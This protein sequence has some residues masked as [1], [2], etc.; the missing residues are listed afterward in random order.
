MKVKARKRGQV[1]VLG[2]V[3]MLLLALSLMMS[4]SVANAV[5]ERIRLQSHADAMAFSMAVVEART[6]NYI[7]YSNRA[8]AASFVSMTTTHVYAAI[9]GS[10]VELMSGMRMAALIATAIEFIVFLASLLEG[11]PDNHRQHW[12]DLLQITVKYHIATEKYK[13]IFQNSEGRFSNAVESFVRLAGDI[14]ASQLDMVGSTASMIQNTPKESNPLNGMGT[15][16]A[17]CATNQ[18]NKVGALNR[19]EFACAMEGS[20]L[21]TFTEAHRRPENENNCPAPSG[22]PHRRQ[23]MSNVV[24]ASRPPFLDSSHGLF[25]RLSPIKGAFDLVA[26]GALKEVEATLKDIQKQLEV[27]QIISSEFSN[28][29]KDIIKSLG[30]VVDESGDLIQAIKDAISNLSELLSLNIIP[31]DVFNNDSGKF[32]QELMVEIPDPMFVLGVGPYRV[33]GELTNKQCKDA[34]F[35]S[36]GDMSCASTNPTFF[37]YLYKDMPG[38][39]FANAVSIASAD[40][41]NPNTKYKGLLNNSPCLQGGN[42]FINFRLDN[43]DKN[44]GQPAVYSYITQPLEAWTKSDGSCS[45]TRQAWELN[46]TGTVRIQHGERG[47]GRLMLKANRDGAAMSKALVYFH[48]M[49]DWRFPPNLFDPY[50]RAKLHP[51]AS[52]AELE[53]VENSAG[54]SQN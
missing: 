33:R 18:T 32:L 2:C 53:R 1:M 26:G 35:S 16:N 15:D 41:G 12:V 8:I 45:Q 31:E 19:G 24:N 43:A 50:W 44:L 20:P 3:T 48:R 10:S 14:H 54:Y 52:K 49:D 46:A 42:C 27:G 17:P 11:D 4:F 47:E 7:A 6:M 36:K 29:I 22:E 5:H 28:E 34:T 25:L 9:L 38:F 30:G 21:D 39:G 23:I 37:M 13:T 51:F 40:N